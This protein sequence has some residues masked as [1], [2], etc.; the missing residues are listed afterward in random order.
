M[1]GSCGK[2]SLTK[3][4]G[5]RGE[6]RLK[7]LVT[8]AI[9]AVVAYAGYQYV[10]VALKAYQFKDYMQQTVD[11]ASALGQNGEWVKTQLKASFNDYDVPPEATITTAQRGGRMEATVQF[12]RPITLPFYTYQYDFN[13][14]AKSTE[15]INVK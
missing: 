15:F 3:R 13:H 2:S 10:P 11:K 9:L 5:E 6:G 1:S 8:V 12:T 7:F 4:R 14:T